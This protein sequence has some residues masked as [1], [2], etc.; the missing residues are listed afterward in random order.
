[1]TTRIILVACLA[2]LLGASVGEDARA[3]GMYVAPWGYEIYEPA[4]LAFIR[5][6]AGAETEELSI[7][8]KFH[9]EPTD[10]AWVVPI[11]A[12]PEVSEAD[13]QLFVDLAELSRPAYRSRD[14][15]WGCEEE[16]LTADYGALEGRDGVE[17]IDEEVVGI[18]RT[19]TLG[20]DDATALMDSLTAWGF[21]HEG[22]RDE[23]E[24]MIRSYVDRDYYFVTM[25]VDSASI[26]G[27]YGGYGKDRPRPAGKAVAPSYY[28]PSLQ[29]VT[30]SFASA[31]IVYPL[32]ISAVSAY[33]ISSVILYVAA[34]HRQTFDG[35]STG[36]AN[37]VT[38]GEL[39]ALRGAYPA[40]GIQLRAG[41]FLTK[42]QRRYTPNEMDADIVL[43][44]ADDDAEYLAVHY[45]GWPFW[46]LVFATVTAAWVVVRRRVARVTR[47][48]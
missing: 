12:L 8:P 31:E 38:P 41:D 24:P 11:P 9:G 47:A 40:A 34:D 45:S 44:R 14:S 16:Y 26:A 48:R 5:Y 1:M 15:F 39:S 25:E 3:D 33:E 27:W 13:P 18:Y 46:S 21:L 23:V 37:R 19:M 10:F 42:L 29:P 30:F 4:Q 7:M 32:R 22:N 36:Y 28:Y 20:A 6:D 35:A 17:I 43:R 2:G